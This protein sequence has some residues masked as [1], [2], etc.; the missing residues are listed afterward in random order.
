MGTKSPDRKAF[1]RQGFTVVRGL[2]P[3]TLRKAMLITACRIFGMQA[4]KLGLSPSPQKG[5]PLQ[6]LDTLSTLLD[7]HDPDAFSW[8]QDMVSQSHAAARMGTAKVLTQSVSRLLACPE[9]ALLRE[10]GRLVPSLPGNT[11][12]LYT[13]HSEASWL[14]LRRNFVNIWTPLFRPK[15][16]GGGS[17]WLVPG[18]H[19]REPWPFIEWRG[20]GEDTLGRK[21]H[22][23]QYDV[24][25]SEIRGLP[26]ICVD[27]E[28]GDVVF[29]H[30]NLLH[31]SELNESPHPTYIWVDRHFDLRADPTLSSNIN[32][33]PYSPESVLAGRPGLRLPR[34]RA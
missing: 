20:H 28:P 30:R 29:F 23:L 13:W 18:S 11:R 5:S 10:G 16:R 22:Y 33:R 1:D 14:P 2:L 19:R 12:R 31:R 3:S 26:G 32:I 17:M 7:E 6:E 25:E 8:A 4:D 27:A 9:E 15:S 34:P 21:D 24:P